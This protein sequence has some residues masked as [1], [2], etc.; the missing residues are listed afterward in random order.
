[1]KKHLRDDYP[2]DRIAPE[3][4]STLE[5]RTIG[6]P[7]RHVQRTGSTNDDLKQAARD[8]AP[9]GLVLSADEQTQGRGRRGRSWRAP[10]G[11]SLLV[12]ALL[13]PTW[14]P[15]ADAFYLTILAT[16][17]CAEA[18]ARVA[19]VPVELK[20]PNDL[21]A[22]GLKLGGILVETEIA[23]GT[24]RW[25]VAGM[26]INVNWDPASVPELATTA[27][28]LASVAGRP[29]SRAELLRTLILGLDDRYTR[30]RAGAK[31]ELFEAWR[32]RLTTLGRGVRVERAGRTF[33][34][35]AE[36][37][38]AR[39]ALIVRDRTGGRHELAAGEV[40]IRS[41]QPEVS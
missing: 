29:I 19:D 23:G 35:I 32:A 14:L 1:M 33:D 6:Q 7:F 40:T 41:Q 30:L 13:R 12:S 15:P 38:T 2:P 31:T 9:E 4:I 25:A 34:G 21:E 11:S 10:P 27:T 28:S 17:A 5:T 20:W 3:A 16:V 26:G 18:I 37:V 36:E 39:G 8:G 22:A 24:I